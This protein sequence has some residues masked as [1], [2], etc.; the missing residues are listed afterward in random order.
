MAGEKERE[1]ALWLQLSW[2]LSSAPLHPL[3]RLKDQGV[4]SP[5]LF[6]LTLHRTLQTIPSLHA[7]QLLF[8]VC[9]LPPAKTAK[10]KHWLERVENSGLSAVQFSSI[11]QTFTE[12]GPLCQALC[13]ELG[14]EKRIQIQDCGL[15]KLH[16]FLV[17]DP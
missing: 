17:L 11:Q 15:Q 12:R 10:G 1:W 2:S 16:S 8:G 5:S 4:S 14:A 9:P 7:L 13:Q 6:P 3:F